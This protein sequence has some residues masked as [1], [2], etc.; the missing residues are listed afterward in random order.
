[1][2]TAAEALRF[3]FPFHHFRDGVAKNAFIVNQRLCGRAAAPRE[4]NVVTAAIVRT[5]VVKPKK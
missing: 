2:K 4:R 3:P 5:K 1:M